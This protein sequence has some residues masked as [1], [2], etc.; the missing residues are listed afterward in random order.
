MLDK[1]LEEG[2]LIWLQELDANLKLDWETVREAFLEEYGGHGDI[3]YQAELTEK[4]WMI[5]HQLGQ[6]G[7]NTAR[8]F[9]LLIQEMDKKPPAPSRFDGSSN[10][11]CHLFEL[12]FLLN[13]L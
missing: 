12:N 2:A 13:F 4:F 9:K 3:S 7:S 10:V 6:K 8:D 11:F 1:C 5:E